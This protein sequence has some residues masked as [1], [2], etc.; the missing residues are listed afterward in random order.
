MIRKTKWALAVVLML[1]LV[2]PSFS[3]QEEQ[4]EQAE[5]KAPR[6][7][8]LKDIL[9]WKNIRSSVISNDGQWFAYMLSPTKGDSEVII[10]QTTGEKEYKFP[11]GEVSGFSFGGLA[12][13]EDS[14]WLAYMIYPD[15]KEAKALKMQKK[16]P[17]NKVGLLNLSSGEKVEFEKTKSF[18]FSGERSEWIALHRYPPES[19]AKEKEKW[20]GSDMILHELATSKELNIGNVSEFAFDKKGIWLA[21]IVDAEE[22]SGNGI[23]L[24]NM[25]TGVVVSLDNDKAVYKRLSWTEE[26]DGLSVLKGKEDEDYEDKL[27]SVIGFTNFSKGSPQKIV[28]DPKEDKNFPEDM[29]ISPNRTPEWTEDFSGILFGIHEAKKKEDKKDK[30]KEKEEEAK[31]KP[32]EAPEKEEPKKKPSPKK[33]EEEEYPD[34]VIWH[35]LDKRLQSMQQVQEN[36]DKNFSFLC[37]YRVKERKFIRLADEE[38]RQ[39][40]AA[41]QHRWAIGLDDREYELTGNL[42]GRR[43][44]DVYVID[45]KTGDRKLTLKKCR[46]YFGPSPDGT[47]FL[48]Y[49]DGHYNTYD[50]ATGKKYN[51]TKDVPTSFINTEDD[52]N[53]KDPPIYPYYFGWVKDGVSVLLYDNWDVWNIPVHGGK[54]VNLTVNG[55][56]EEIR[57]R[58]RYRLDPEEEGID[59]SLPLYIST[60]GEWTKKGGV[61]R[62]DKGKPGAKILLWDDALFSIMKAKDAEVY[63]YTRQTHK[64]YPDY[65]VTDSSL[66][67]GLKITDAGAQQEEFLWS[68]GS[69]LLDYESAKGDKLQAAL[70]LPANYEK[71]KSYPM[72]VYIY[73][74]L[75][76]SLHRY[77]TPSANG[78]NKSVYTSNG[79]AVLMPDIVY[80][81]NDPG[82]SAVWCVLPAIEAAIKTGV[83]DRNNIAI[84]GHSWGGYQTAFLITQSDIFKAAVAG[85]PLTNMISMYSSIYW[86]TGSAN[87]PI[88]ESSQGR[89]EGGYWENIEAYMRN[90]PVN[91]ATN[92]KT[93]LLLLHNDKDGAVDWN[94]GIEYF[95]TLRRLKKPVVMLQYKGENHGLRIPANREDYTI[96]MRQFFDHYLKGEPAPDWLK[97]GISH[98]EM[99]DHL[100]E[101]AK[102]KK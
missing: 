61:A 93:P 89:F 37:V 36:R 51:I 60:Y 6:P 72:V 101:I 81:V 31:D 19:Q 79:Y 46:W 62:V 30:E 40:V 69:M 21:W 71:E 22:M 98:L 97:E 44:Q 50:M 58:S 92:V 102:E 5:L 11:V 85:A 39:V 32:K 42:E 57:Y 73:E 27:Y 80:K 63:L 3:F 4:K 95:N 48:Y 15:E 90:S 91:F 20:S 54:G 86:N 78:F 16:T 43:Y 64:D 56:K 29:T 52:H 14:K 28:Y 65:Y 82:M 24:R 26:G 87:Q 88:F 25:Q 9:A 7:I 75:S 1:F 100:K 83:V 68:S 45:L 12:F 17:Y 13:S 35:W 47:H 8:G 67:K 55:K 2:I 33:E 70:F 94:Q 23:Q 18:Q 38:V 99:K 53:V 41:P 74:K 77:F 76:Q 59:L 10:R 49:E 34:L 66:K 84:H 96:R